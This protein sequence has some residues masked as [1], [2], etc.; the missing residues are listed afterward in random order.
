MTIHDFSYPGWL[1]RVTSLRCVDLEKSKNIMRV[2]ALG[3]T[4]STNKLVMLV[5]MS[6]QLSV[7]IGV[8]CLAQADLSQFQ[9]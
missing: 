5:V 6:L 7:A 2:G 9:L 1:D 3:A 4:E 8:G